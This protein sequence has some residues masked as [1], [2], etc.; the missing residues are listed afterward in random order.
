MQKNNSKLIKFI[1][2]NRAILLLGLVIITTLAFR[3][4]HLNLLP[5]GLHPDE[6]ANGLD[7]LNRIFHAD[8]RVIYN[9]N[10]PRESLFFFLQAIFVA[11]LGNTILA[12]RMAP[13]LIGVATVIMVYFL[14]KDWF[15]RRTALV[16]SFL[17]AINPWVNTISRDGFRASMVALMIVSV[18]FFAGKAYKTTKIIY[19]VL[20]GFVFG[21]GFYTYTA[22]S[23]FALVPLL[24]LGYLL[25]FNRQWL[26]SNLVKLSISFA[27]VLVVITPLVVTIIKNPADS[28]ARAGGT[29]FLNKDL[30][31]GQPIATL[32]QSSVKTLLQFNYHGDENNRH[33]LAGEPFLNTFVGIMLILGLLVSFSRFKRIKYA[34]IIAMFF[35]MMLPAATTAEGIPH[36]LRSIGTSASVFIL[37]AIGVD[38]LLQRWYRTFP[39]NTPARTV[40][41]LSIFILLGLSAVLGWNQY[42]I[43]WAQDPVTY[44]AYGENMVQIGY[45]LNNNVSQNRQNYLVAGGYESMPVEYLT[46]HKSS[47][48]LLNIEKLQAQPLSDT[49]QLFVFP[50]D[51]D[52]SKKIEILKAKYTDGVIQK[53]NSSFSDK[54]L[55]YSF[56]VK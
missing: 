25:I 36:G 27:I 21:L 24:G 29:S 37:A 30:N 35:I 10:G 1:L 12:L 45:Y 48:N 40:G 13:A 44:T 33:N 4:Y 28:S 32:I 5:P 26:K 52:S 49:S 16:A 42:F 34:A 7:I 43:A 31:N 47:Y 22:Y 51:L 46:Y 3:L 6:A 2:S 14:T 50:A 56:S 9:T 11:M 15:G 23:A 39:I 38:Y 41:T 54:L 8:L 18:A 53:H 17:I 55:F 20:A 19:F